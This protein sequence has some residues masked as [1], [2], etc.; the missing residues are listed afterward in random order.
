MCKTS[1]LFT[2]YNCYSDQFR[3][4]QEKKKQ[5]LCLIAFRPLKLAE[6]KTA[7][8]TAPTRLTV[9]PARNEQ[10]ARTEKDLLAIRAHVRAELKNETEEMGETRK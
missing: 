1:F 4:G 10:E 2:A 9:K 3:L 6:T 8:S 7:S 5:D